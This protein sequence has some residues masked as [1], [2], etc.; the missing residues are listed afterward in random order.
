MT[1]SVE[2][3]LDIIWLINMYISFTTTYY[4]EMEEVK[5]F[6]KI[7]RRYLMDGFFIDFISTVASLISYESVYQIY[8]LKILRLY[9]VFRATRIVKN[10]ISKLDEQITIS[11]Q[12]VYKLN[13]GANF[14]VLSLVGMHSVACIWLYIGENVTGGW[15]DY[16]EQNQHPLPDRTS[17]YIT[18]IYWTVT[19]LATIGYGD[20]KGRT[21]IEYVYNMAVEFLGIA[22]FSYTMSSV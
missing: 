16:Y 12:A 22:F 9:F 19:T 1:W 14:I 17:R 3:A 13:Y 6:K 2:V 7:A 5:I 18:S 21:P 10:K 11:K 15:I 4:T 8:Y 20:V